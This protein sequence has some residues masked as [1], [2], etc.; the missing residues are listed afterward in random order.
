MV[1]GKVE[2]RKIENTTSRQVTFS[3]RRNGL[4]KKAGELSVLC[5]AEVGVVVFSQRG[6][7]SEFSSHGMDK[8]IARYQKYAPIEINKINNADSCIQQLKHESASLANKIELLKAS[9]R[10]LLGEGLESCTLEEIKDTSEILE[11]SLTKVRLRKEQLFMEQMEILRLQE[12]ELLEKKASLCEK[13]WGPPSTGGKG[14]EPAA[15]VATAGSSNGMS[16]ESSTVVETTLS[17]GLP[18][19][20]H[21]ALN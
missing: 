20:T 11:K 3:K 10:K 6:R 14:K 21:W 17:I 13:P 16:N 18:T 9:T 12:K 1:R 2:V 4:L 8:T 7:L 15:A 19:A 5:D